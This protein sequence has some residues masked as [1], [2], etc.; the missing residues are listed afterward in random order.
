M[1]EY[2][3]KLRFLDPE[4]IL[5]RAGLANGQVVADLGAGSGFYALAASKVVGKTG[6]VYVVDI[7][8]SALANVAA[9]A[10]MLMLKNLTAVRSDLEKQDSLSKISDSSIDL[11]IF[12]N[13]L[14]QL[15]SYRSLLAETYRVLKT[16]GHLL[17]VEWSDKPGPFGP[18]SANRLKQAD[19]IAAITKSGMKF[20]SEIETD[21][22]H[23]GLTFIK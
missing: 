9:E 6:K 13:V 18:R 10:R 7:L 5:F 1:Q 15:S 11:A 12:G 3:T 22:Y 8:D 4:K 23:Y 21:P 17:V 16:K 19:V 2:K 14:H 20:E